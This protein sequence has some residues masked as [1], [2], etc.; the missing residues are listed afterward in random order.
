MMRQ[1]CD[2]GMDLDEFPNFTNVKPRREVGSPAQS[3]NLGQKTNKQLRSEHA[4]GISNPGFQSRVPPVLP[5]S[6]FK[7]ISFVSLEFTSKINFSEA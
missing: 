7:K 4:L 6:L 1:E 2:F 5:F 3:L